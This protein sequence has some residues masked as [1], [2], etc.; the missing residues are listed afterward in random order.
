MPKIED[1]DRAW[2]IIISA[3]EV[4]GYDKFKE[5]KLWFGNDY[6]DCSVAKWIFTEYLNCDIPVMQTIPPLNLLSN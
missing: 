1:V 4:Q 3:K 5:S 6:S 2:N